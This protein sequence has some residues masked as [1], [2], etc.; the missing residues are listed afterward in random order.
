MTFPDE[1]SV[2]QHALLLAANGL[3]YV[4]PNPPV[5]AVIVDENL[6][7][8][9][10]GYHLAFG[11][12][13]AEVV[14]LSGVKTSLDNATL[15][16]TL[17]PCC[18]TG[19]TGPCSQAIIQSG[20]K[21]VVVAMQDPASYVSGKGIEKL[22]AAGIEVV[23]GLLREKGERLLA[24]FA[25][26]ITKQLPYV[27]A[28][29]AMS[30][31]G[32]IATSTGDSQWI[33]NEQS[34]AQVHLLRGRMDAILVGLKTALTD[35]PL[36]T[37][38][39]AGPR[40]AI[41]I[42]LDSNASLPVDSQLVQTINQAPLLVVATTSAPQQNIERL[43]QHGVEVLTLPAMEGSRFP[44]LRELLKELGRKQMTHLLVEG[45]GMVLGSFFDLQLVDETHLFIA[46]K[47]IG[48]EH[49]LSPVGG[50]GNKT[51]PQISLLE[52]KEVQFLGEDI[53]IR[54]FIHSK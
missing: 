23:V 48:G 39:P 37:A 24:P 15:F 33:S 50:V 32:K 27:H 31:D 5:G 16:V 17:E 20:I 35:D 41:R 49:S 53:Y 29:W 45:G 43:Q 13:H 3:G 28:K 8:I 42:V 46:P 9:S 18:H 14:A 30:L 6:N 54:G 1:Q 21:R 11:A 25:K 51:V 12:P 10:E 52:Q 38:R 26:F 47:I 34:R 4:E 44:S 40:I 19:K 2:M 22:R 7:L 36:L